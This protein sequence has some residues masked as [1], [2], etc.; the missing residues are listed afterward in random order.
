[1]RILHIA[2]GGC[3]K[4]PPV[5]YGITEDTGGHIAYVLGA[6]MAQA[7]QPAVQSVQIVTRGFL[8]DG[9]DPVHNQAVEQVAP[10]CTIHRLFTKNTGYLSKEALEAE[11]PALEAAFCQLLADM[12][13]QPDVIHAHFADAARL[14]HAAEKMFGIPWV[15]TPHSLA[16]QKGADAATRP[17]LQSRIA[18][19]RQAVTKAG[20]IIVSS[21]DEAESQ[22]RPYCPDSEGRSYRI[23]PGVTLANDNGTVAAKKLIAPFLRDPGKPVLLA[24]ARPVRKKNLI[25]LVEA[26]AGSKDLQQQCNLVILAGLRHGTET[27][28]AEQSLVIRRLFDCIDRHNLWGKVALPARHDGAQLRSLY[29]LAAEGGAFVNPALHEPF[30]LTIVEAAQAGVPVVA[31]RNGGPIDILAELDAG[32]LVD[33]SDPEDI[34]QGCLAMLNH[35]R[36]TWLAKKAQHRAKASFSWNTWADAALLVYERL[37]TPR[38]TAPKGV[39][40][41]F[42]SDIDGTLTG[43]ND[44]ARRFGYWHGQQ[45]PTNLMFAIATGRS[46]TEA[47]RVL[48]LWSLPQPE[49]FITSVGSEIWRHGAC[50]NLYLCPDYAAYLDQHWIRSDVAACLA[51]LKLHW[52]QHYEQRRWKLS[53]LGDAND[54]SSVRTALDTAGLSAHVIASHGRFIDILPANAGKAAALAFEAKRIGLTLDDCITAGDSG[55]DADMLAVGGASILP[56]NAYSELAHI[57]G[58]AIYRSSFAHAAGVLDGLQRLGLTG[59]VIGGDLH[60]A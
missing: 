54:A 4:A 25:A 49:V 18:T 21:R 20:A 33:P 60:H 34:A 42:A 43:C 46:V 12:D 44:A 28:P 29:A 19:E 11:I 37:Q 3:L 39:D 30:G 51:G 40:R 16:L 24:V 38:T 22:L 7:C 15:Y 31:T 9:L 35:P 27:G 45:K 50:G 2:L 59:S 1:M 8:Q 32:K 57:A 58:P 53:L 6:A 10:S 48:N 52:Q 13:H 47:R 26:Y 56:S 23:N 36:K 5:E 17:D 55:N 41:L 14:A